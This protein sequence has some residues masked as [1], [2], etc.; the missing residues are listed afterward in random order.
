MT[1][2]VLCNMLADNFLSQLIF[3]PHEA[4]ICWTC[5]LLITLKCFFSVDIMDN[6]PGTDHNALQY[7]LAYNYCNPQQY[8]WLLNNYKKADFIYFSTILSHVPWHLIDDIES[9]LYT[10]SLLQ[11]MLPYLRLSGR[12]VI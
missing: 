3:F 2:T 1:A 10:Y 4:Q 8:K 7:K 12:N 9:S 6:L 11:L 5:F